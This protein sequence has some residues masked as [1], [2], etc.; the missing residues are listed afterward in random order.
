MSFITQAPVPQPEPA[1]RTDETK[2]ALLKQRTEELVSP[3]IPLAEGAT[4]DI[5]DLA[6]AI[7]AG[8]PAGLAADDFDG[9]DVTEVLAE[10][11]APQGV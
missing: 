11:L 2:R 4:I 10:I 8:L 3:V 9:N 6:V 1:V 5:F 7:R